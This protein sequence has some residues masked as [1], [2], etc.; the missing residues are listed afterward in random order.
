MFLGIMCYWFMRKVILTTEQKS[1]IEELYSSGKSRKNISKELNI[2]EHAIRQLI[3]NSDLLEKQYHRIGERYGRLVILDKV[4][5]AKNGSP[6]VRCQCDCGV[7]KDYNI[8]NIT[9]PDMKGTKSCG[10]YRKELH[11]SKDVWQTEYN[12]YIG[13]TIKKRGWNFPLTIDEFKLLCSSNCFYCG[14]HP[15]SPM[16]VGNGVKNGIDRI[17][18]SIGYELS[19]CVPCCWTC[20]RMKGKMSHDEFICHIQKIYK[21]NIR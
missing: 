20:N 21:H 16:D 13:N 18:N 9:Y 8:G 17:N 3:K 1:K 12:A 5:R 7:I 14:C 6:I 19:N 4:G 15:Q 2:S 11:S 10:C